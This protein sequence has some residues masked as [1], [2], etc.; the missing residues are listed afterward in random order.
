MPVAII[1]ATKNSGPLIGRHY[2]QLVTCFEGRSEP[3]EIMYVDDGSRD[4]STDIIAELSR[5]DRRVR[6]IFL[7]QSCGQQAALTVGLAATAGD[8]FLT[9]DV[10]LEVPADASGP[11]VDAIR[12]GAD[13]AVGRRIQRARRHI[14]R[15]VGSILFNI[16]MRLMT[17]L[18]ISD[19]G[20][21]AS[22][23]TRTLANRAF[24]SA[25]PF[26]GVKHL[27]GQLADSLVEV[28]VRE[29]ALSGHRS[30][31]GPRELLRTLTIEHRKRRRLVLPEHVEISETSGP[32][33]GGAGAKSVPS[34]YLFNAAS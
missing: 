16:S 8:P 24:Q 31:Y 22:A 9:L 11:L 4:Q 26:R 13:Y 21:G 29:I 30:A 10:D 34:S 27:L 19:F 15:S 1:T 5:C 7:H 17:R 18:P 6:G 2:R 12:S 32:D 23:G 33:T 25:I 20:C 28:P 14:S 3:F